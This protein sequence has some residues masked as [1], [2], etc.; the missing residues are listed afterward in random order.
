V[1]LQFVAKL[2]A[3]C[4][5]GGDWCGGGWVALNLSREQLSSTNNNHYITDYFILRVFMRYEYLSA[6]WFSI[7]KMYYTFPKFW[8]IP[9]H[10]YLAALLSLLYTGS[11]ADVCD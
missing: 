1:G 11:F 3:A 4:G 10:L 2:R 9:A 5:G 7:K 8:M 6:D